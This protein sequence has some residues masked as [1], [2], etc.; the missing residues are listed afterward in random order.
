MKLL[1]N[2]VPVWFANKGIH[3][4]KK[5]CTGLLE[6][7]QKRKHLDF[8]TN[9]HVDVISNILLLVWIKPFSLAFESSK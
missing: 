5:Y 9:L 4:D 3:V 8:K 6:N 1:D 2:Y 7:Y